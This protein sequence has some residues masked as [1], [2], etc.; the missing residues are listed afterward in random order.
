MT[1]RFSHARDMLS[2]LSAA[3]YCFTRRRYTKSKFHRSTVDPDRSDP[4]G[5]QLPKRERLCR[6]VCPT[7]LPRYVY[8][9]AGAVH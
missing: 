8:C 2:L 9:S 7:D 6:R 3:V 1:V 4:E 5:S